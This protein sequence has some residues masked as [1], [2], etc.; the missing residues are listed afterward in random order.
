MKKTMTV[1]LKDVK[2]YATDWLDEI[3]KN[4]RKLI[5]TVLSVFGLWCGAK[6]YIE[7]SYN[8]SE[9]LSTLMRLVSEGRILKAFVM[10]LIINLVPILLSF[11][12]GFF[13]FGMPLSMLSPCLSG[14]IIGVI[15]AWLFSAYRLNGVFFSLLSLVPFAVGI[16]I[17]L[18]VSCNESILLS[19]QITKLIFLKE[20]GESGEVKDFFIRHLI[21]IS[22]S[23]AITLVQTVVM[24]NLYGKLL[25]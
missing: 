4:R 17:M 16:T 25:I 3:I 8:V 11:L 22:V 13:A 2:N 9:F 12:N 15:N 6:V 1:N 10:L 19:G 20:T 7:Y 14:I 21:I 5:L 24:V 23:V 18:L